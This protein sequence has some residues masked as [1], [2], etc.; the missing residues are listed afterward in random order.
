LS[1]R[2]DKFSR[3]LKYSFIFCECM[4]FLFMFLGFVSVE[5]SHRL[6]AVLQ[7]EEDA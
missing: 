7:F 3:I 1:L 5:V 2:A 6:N 4:I